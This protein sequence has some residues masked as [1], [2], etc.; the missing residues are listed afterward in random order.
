MK[1][2]LPL[3][4]VLALIVLLPV[5]NNTAF[6]RESTKIVVAVDAS[7][8]AVNDTFKV[9]V[10]ALKATDLYGVQFTLNYNPDQIQVVS[11]GVKLEKNMQVF[12]GVTE[13]FNKGKLT[14]PIINTNAKKET[15]AN[16]PI[17][18]FTFKALK[19]GSVV[20]TLT[21]IKAVNS[22]TDIKTIHE[23]TQH[24]VTFNIKDGPAH[25]PEPTPKPTPKPTPEPTPKPTPKP[26]PTPT[27]KPT[28]AP[29]SKPT[30]KPTPEPTVKPTSKPTPEPTK[31]PSPK[32]TVKPTPTAT[33]RPTEKP[34]A[35]PAF[36]PTEKPTAAPTE[37]PAPASSPTDNGPQQTEQPTETEDPQA[38]AEPT[39]EPAVISDPGDSDNGGSTSPDDT[40]PDN[41]GDNENPQQNSDGKTSE[42]KENTGRKILLYLIMLMVTAA[43]VLLGIS[44]VKGSKGSRKSYL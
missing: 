23:N 4:M 41:S 38:T 22:D 10:R 5:S 8:I 35:S 44:L 34:T 9:Y 32:P 27:P 2:I 40:N 25:T 28:A 17:A 7:D 19:K 33:A 29:T 31:E 12:G 20:I 3:L 42:V 11:N 16:I 21:N 43:V 13:D 26:T 6:A 30:P 24:Q 36:R 14:Y 1:R 37:S 18:E 39:E 15:I